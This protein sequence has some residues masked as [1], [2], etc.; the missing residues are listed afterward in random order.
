MDTSGLKSP[1]LLDITR[2]QRRAEQ[3]LDR[4]SSAEIPLYEENTFT[5]T[6][7]GTTTAGTGTYTAAQNGR[8]TRI[9]R[10][11]F[12]ELYVVWTNLTG[13]AGSLA[14]GGLPFTSSSDSTF[15]AVAIGWANNIA[16]TASNVMTAYV[17]NNSTQIYLFQYPAGG[18]AATAVPIDTA[19][20]IILCGQYSL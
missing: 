8:Y 15:P 2:L 7:R 9:G 20:G 1:A 11:V 3:T 14:V 17:Q 6:I 4:I 19:G 10:V 12:F 16:L 13:A 18:G 5:P